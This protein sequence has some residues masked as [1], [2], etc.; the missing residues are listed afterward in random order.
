MVQY[1]TWDV[2]D[3]PEDRTIVNW[4][5]VSMIK[6]HAEGSIERSKARL[7]GKAR[8]IDL[9]EYSA[10][11]ARFDSL[12]LHLAVGACRNCVPQQLDIKA[13]F[14]YGHLKEVTDMHL[15]EGANG[16]GASTL[17]DDQRHPN[18][19]LLP[20]VATTFRIK[21]NP[22]NCAIDE[23][24]NGLFVSFPPLSSISAVPG[25]VYH[26]RHHLGVAITAVPSHHRRVAST[27][28]RLP[29]CHQHDRRSIPAVPS[30]LPTP[31]TSHLPRSPPQFRVISDDGV[32]SEPS[33]KAI[34]W[35]RHSGN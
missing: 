34:G 12:R 21:L 31:A 23:L 35:I 27:A 4:M 20:A 24:E 29:Q 18:M 28:A 17:I 19:N 9:N 33:P 7:V 3:R 32:S 11:V 16:D 30:P 10:P 14:I 26:H 2:V 5:W 6:V 13:A 8:A 22:Y 25:K 15:R 1:D